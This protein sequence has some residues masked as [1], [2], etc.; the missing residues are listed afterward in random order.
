MLDSSKQN[1]LFRYTREMKNQ[2]EKLA[3]THTHT[4]TFREEKIGRIDLGSQLFTVDAKG[5]DAK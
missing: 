4:H 5:G 2:I 1:M 3:H